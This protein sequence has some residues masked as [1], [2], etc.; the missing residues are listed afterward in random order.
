LPSHDAERHKPRD[1]AG[2]A[3]AG[4]NLDDA[5]DALVGLGRL[6]RELGVERTADRVL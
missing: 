1:P 2:E 3:R 5:I 6:L 4:D